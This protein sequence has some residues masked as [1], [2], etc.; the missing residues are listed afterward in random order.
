MDSK[1]HKII[2]NLYVGNI[3]AGTDPYILKKYNI[4]CVINCTTKNTR[5]D[6][7]DI[8]INYLQIPINDPP[9]LND[10]QFVNNKF[11]DIIEYINN[12]LISGSNVLI[13]FVA[14]SQRSA[15]IAA[16]YLMFKFK[17]GYHQ[18]CEFIKSKRSVCF[19]GSINY[20]SSLHKIQYDLNKLTNFKN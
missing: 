7:K 14:G 6:L 1:F 8:N 18:A 15:T 19:F 20:L 5:E 13:H 3:S 17:M 9:D 10:I 4:N 2:D 16:I 12:Q 11:L